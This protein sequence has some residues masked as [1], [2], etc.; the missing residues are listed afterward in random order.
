MTAFE[1][2]YLHRVAEGVID[3]GLKIKEYRSQQCFSVVA[4]CDQYKA[5]ECDDSL[6]E[7]LA[8]RPSATNK[9]ELIEREMPNWNL[10]GIHCK[11]GHRI[12]LPDPTEVYERLAANDEQHRISWLHN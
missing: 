11:N 4:P 12:L 8:A 10:T 3:E 9:N 6:I 7:L 2:D 1:Y 5:G